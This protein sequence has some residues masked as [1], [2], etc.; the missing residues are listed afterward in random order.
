MNKYNMKMN[1]Y[2]SVVSPNMNQRLSRALKPGTQNL[3]CRGWSVLSV[4]AM[5][6][7]SEGWGDGLLGSGLFGPI[8]RGRLNTRCPV[9]RLPVFATDST[10]PRLTFVPLEGRELCPS[11]WILIRMLSRNTKQVEKQTHIDKL[12]NTH[13]K[14]L[15]P[16]L[17][18]A[19][20][21]N[22]LAL[23]GHCPNS[24]RPPLC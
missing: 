24:F 15:W 22:E 23:Y 5:Q 3:L 4:A 20:F 2:I 7:W 16:W 11:I 18:E 21:W 14:T 12:T 19:P 8:I 17:R 10:T 13:T 9:K 1:K 6:Y